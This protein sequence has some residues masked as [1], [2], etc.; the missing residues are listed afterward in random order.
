VTL[1]SQTQQVNIESHQCGEVVN[2]A[3]AIEANAK[4]F[5]DVYTERSVAARSV[6]VQLAEEPAVSRSVWSGTG[7][8]FSG[9]MLTG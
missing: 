7:H 5:S 4:W 8:A 6:E 3:I 1:A 9:V 2:G